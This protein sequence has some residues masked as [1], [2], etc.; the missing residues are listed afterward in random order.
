MALIEIRGVT[1][2]FGPAP[3]TALRKL[4]SGLDK[5]ALL[6]SGHTL[7]LDDVDLDI[8]AGEIFVVMGPSGS[9]KSTLLRHIN[10]LIEP[11]AGRVFVDGTDV[12]ALGPRELV[13]LRRRRMAM[14]FQGF[15]LLDHRSVVDNVALGLEL[16]GVGQRERRTRAMQWIE[17]VG[18]SG[19][20]QHLP[21]QLSGGMRQ[22]V[23]LA[24]ALA[25]ETDIVLMD[26][27]FSA[28][29]PPIRA[30]LQ[31]ELLALQA[32][33]GRTVVF[34]THDLDEALRLGSRLAILCDGAVVQV[35]TPWEVLTRP[36]D[37]PTADFARHVN[38]A[39]A[40]AIGSALAPWPA[41]LPMPAPGNTT[42]A[43][44]ADASIEQVLHRLV[45]R[46]DPLA[47]R[48]GSVIV[49][50]VSMSSVRALLAPPDRACS[51]STSG[52]GEKRSG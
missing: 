9:G 23:G 45:G 47:V 52:G 28:L 14:V 10:R 21:E 50:Q 5:A 38:R 36:A 41:D 44:D 20:E 48:R 32:E 1:T 40:L 42:D 6:A 3:P 43:V 11:T 29:D 33:Q 37:D 12:M 26:E 34:V 49:G 27:P 22:R 35:G 51:R 16:R 7:G 19:Y 4:R 24:R 15:G 30:Q 18:L 2:I 25:S 46:T 17:R 39:R 31:Q 13:A 8:R